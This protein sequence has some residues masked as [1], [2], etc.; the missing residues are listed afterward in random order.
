MRIRRLWLPFTSLLLIASFSVG[1]QSQ[2]VTSVRVVRAA[3]VLEQPVGDARAVGSAG[4]GEILDVLDERNGWYF[5]RP[6]TGGPAREWRTGW[7]TAVTVE[8]MR[9]GPPG[10]TVPGPPAAATSQAEASANRKGFIIGGGVGGGLHRPPGFTVF[11]RFGRVAATGGGTNNV[12]IVTNFSRVRAVSPSPPPPPPLPLPLSRPLL[13]PPPPPPLPTPLSPRRRVR[14][15]TSWVR[16]RE[17]IT[18]L[19]PQRVRRARAS[20]TTLHSPSA[21]PTRLRVGRL[22]GVVV[23]SA[24]L[25]QMM[26]SATSGQE[27]D[28]SQPP[29]PKTWSN[30]MYLGGVAGIRGKS[31]DWKNTLTVSAT[32]IRFEGTGKQPIRFEIS[33]A[34]VRALDYSGHKRGNAEQG[35]R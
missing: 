33:T 14:P 30:V 10:A 6:P 26:P 28:K 1:A 27:V 22:A 19:D 25:L 9:S 18:E 21:L 15:T 13:P 24:A 7:V 31:L 11:D 29:A 20:M 3:A 16:F 23:F 8:P 12:S 32:A 17:G 35:A 2:A 4:T 34:S 5:V